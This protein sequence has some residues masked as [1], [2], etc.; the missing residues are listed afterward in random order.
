MKKD[1]KKQEIRKN[2]SSCIIEKFRSFDTVSTEYG[3]NK[4]L[5]LLGLVL[6]INQ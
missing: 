2:L 6:Y 4:E 3:R 5:S 1:S